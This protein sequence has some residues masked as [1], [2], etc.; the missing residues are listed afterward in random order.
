[1][2]IWIWIVLGIA[3]DLGEGAMSTIFCDAEPGVKQ[4]HG[5][6]GKWWKGYSRGRSW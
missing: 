6:A 3:R 2:W 1:M 5:S 4:N